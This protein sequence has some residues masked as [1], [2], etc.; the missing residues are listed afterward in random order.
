M[1][2]YVCILPSL[3]NKVDLDISKK[4]ELHP[5]VDVTKQMRRNDKENGRAVI[6]SSFFPLNIFF[7]PQTLGI[8]T[9]LLTFI[10]ETHCSYYEGLSSLNLYRSL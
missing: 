3:H 9:V 8:T 1:E 6:Y 7:R 10:F 5:T 4:F 2:K